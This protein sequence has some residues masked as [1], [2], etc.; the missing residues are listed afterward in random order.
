MTKSLPTDETIAAIATAVAAGEGGIAI[1]RISGAA[2]LSACK[3]IVSVPGS[4]SWHSHS[5]LYGH[6]MNEEGTKR[7]DEVLVMVMKGPRSFTGEDIVEIHCHGGMISVQRVL[8][9]VLSHPQIRRAI[10]GEFSQR[11]VING[12]LNLTQAESISEL[13]HARSNQAAQLA[14]AGLDGGIQKRIAK[15]RDILLD[16]LSELEARVDFEDELPTLDGSQVLKTLTDVQSELKQLIND[17]FTASLLQQGLKV[18][19]IGAPNVGKS[20][21]LNRLSRRERAIVTD[22]PGTTR[23]VLESEIVIEGV[24]ITLLDTAGIRATA[25]PIEKLGIAKSQEVLMCADIVLVVFDLSKGWTKQ[26][27]ALFQQIPKNTSK[28]LIANKVDIASDP[29]LTS[30]ISS[31]NANETYIA[32]SALT[33][34][35]VQDVIDG[36]LTLCGAH[37]IQGIEIALNERQRDLAAR[38]ASALDR[39]NTVATQKLP[40]DFWTIDLREA[41][42]CLGEITGNELTE[43]LLDRIFSRFC[44]GK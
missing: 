26:D 34:E 16:Q 37:D 10:P 14:M 21:L 6:V 32:F 33:G 1:V 18:A 3:S 17:A 24:P 38:A 15:L 27:E 5:I 7:I 40:W 11:A 20:S 9:R 4:K 31:K 13:I 39:T 41:I 44:I 23:D 19:L 42:Q 25:N 36:L 28:L 22:L 30:Q 2:A 8:E 35:G 43:I 29:K 12:R